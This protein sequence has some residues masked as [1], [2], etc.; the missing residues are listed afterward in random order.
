MSKKVSATVP[1]P[2]EI[3]SALRY[4]LRWIPIAALVGL[5][6][7]TASA[8]LLV[9][10]DWA[11]ATREAHKGMILFL[12]FVG[13]FV[14]LLYEYL[15]PTVDGGNNLILDQIHAEADS[16]HKVPF[17]M[18][19]LILLATFLSHLFGASVGREG[20]AVQMGASLA[21]Q[22]TR[23]F[24]LDSRGR[25]VLLMAGISAGFGSVFGTPLAG[26]IFGI[27][28]LTLGSINL[29]AIAPCFLAAFLGDL[30]TRA[31]GVHHVLY[32]VTDVPHI[33]LAGLACSALA[34][35][36]FGLVALTFARTMHAVSEVFKGTVTWQPLRP[37]VGGVVVAGGVIAMGTTKYVGIGGNT[38]S[39]AF[40][41]NL[42]P[43]DWAVKLLFTGLSLGSGFKGGEVTPLFF[44]GAT[45]GNSLAHFL[46][47]PSSL[48]AGMGFAAVFAG[49]SNTPIASSLM[50]MELFGAEAGTY[51]AIACVFSYLFSGHSGIYHSQRIASKKYLDT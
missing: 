12:P 5:L 10:L 48:L 29:E 44:I 18:T 39:A 23:P 36:I 40:N 34:G 27:E 35:A 1:A 28:V 32:R 20:T 49:A 9:S 15:G 46:P 11:T 42:P 2:A 3:L 22:L 38:I 19:P 37:F 43:Y 50:A 31:W 45:L 4:L 17:R 51:A 41:S 13:I 33:D 21:D 26:A 16:Q 7:G 14:G 6:G 24:R 25:R 47:L 30:V 8:M